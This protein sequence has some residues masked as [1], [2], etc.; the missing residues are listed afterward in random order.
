MKKA[1]VLLTAAAALLAVTSCTKEGVYN[2]KEKIVKIYES[3]L[4]S[5]INSYGDQTFTYSDTTAKHLTQEWNWDGNLLTSISYYNYNEQ[6]KE[7]V[8]SYKMDMI[9]DGKRLVKVASSSTEYATYTYEDNKIAKIESYYNGELQL[10]RAITH[11]GKKIVKIVMT[12]YDDEIND[13]LAKFALS[14]LMPS[15]RALDA[16]FAVRSDKASAVA[17]Q[18]LDFTYDGNNVSKMVMTY[19][20]ETMTME[21]T[22][23]KNKNPF[24]GNYALSAGEGDLN[25]INANNVLT[26]KST[27]QRTGETY[28]PQESTYTY[29]YDGKYPVTK[30]MTQSSVDG[31]Y[32]RSTYTHTTYLEYAD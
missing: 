20:D 22:Y 7:S 8:F 1:L 32:Y 5:T 6:T 17:T 4:N 19:G 13:D 28:D 27:W 3:S 11:D 29:E 26:E 2:P 25:C 14:S 9:Y 10:S 12:I 16:V 18:T 23:D 21:F 31:D 24:C 15:K 30:T